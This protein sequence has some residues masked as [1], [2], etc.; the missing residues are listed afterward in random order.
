MPLR[1]R[2]LAAL[3]LLPTSGCSAP[4]DLPGSSADPASEEPELDSFRTFDTECGDAQ[5][6]NESTVVQ[7]APDVCPDRGHGRAARPDGERFA[8][9]ECGADLSGVK[10]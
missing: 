8:C 3:A 5:V 9:P 6:S 2:H 10:D 4:T 1:P 7:P